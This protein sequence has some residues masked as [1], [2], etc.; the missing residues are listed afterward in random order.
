MLYVNTFEPSRVRFV[1]GDSA[2]ELV[3]EAGFPR[4]GQSVITIHASRAVRSPSES[5]PD[6]AAPLRIGDQEFGA[7]WATTPEKAWND[8]DQ[9]NFTYSLRGRVIRG[10]MPIFRVLRLRGDRTCSPSTPPGIQG[11]I[12]WRNCG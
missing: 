10:S 11:W 4:I 2:V 6:W 12:R 7:G 9:V 5:G 3:Q 1:L 8:N